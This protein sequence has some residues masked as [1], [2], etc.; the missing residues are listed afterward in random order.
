MARWLH[1]PNNTVPLGLPEPHL[2]IQ[3]YASQTGIGF[4]IN[5]TRY[6]LPLDNSLEASSIN[7]LELLAIWLATLMINQRN[8]ILR[9]MT[10]NATALSAINKASSGTYHLAS[11]AEMIW[12]RASIMKWTL[13]AVHIKGSFNV[14]AD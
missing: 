3:S 10:D 8:I 14:V 5:S 12:K 13:S 7:V 1:L 6:Q 11:I 4:I 2:K 9:L